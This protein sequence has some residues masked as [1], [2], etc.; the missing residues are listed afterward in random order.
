MAGL[1]DS[2]L[3]LT[4]LIDMSNLML[5]CPSPP[6]GHADRTSGQWSWL[7]WCGRARDPFSAALD[8]RDLFD[9]VFKILL[10]AL[11]P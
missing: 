6:A 11:T 9:E 5:F 8:G 2:E 10:L 1:S 3:R 4:K 7:A